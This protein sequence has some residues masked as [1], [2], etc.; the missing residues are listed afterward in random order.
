M[1]VSTLVKQGGAG[2]WDSVRTAIH[3]RTAMRTTRL[4]LGDR[5]IASKNP[6]F[7]LLKLARCAMCTGSMC[8]AA[9]TG[10]PVG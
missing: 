5:P 6:F 9:M 2:A 3:H 8:T 7:Q 4:L 10:E 1:D